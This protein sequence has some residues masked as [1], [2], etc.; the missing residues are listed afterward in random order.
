MKT[1]PELHWIKDV[2]TRVHSAQGLKDK[3]F[4]IKKRSVNGG[5]YVMFYDMEYSKLDRK[6]KIR[7]QFSNFVHFKVFRDAKHFCELINKG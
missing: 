4:T 7:E 6:F 5:Y 1:I 3:F 2:K